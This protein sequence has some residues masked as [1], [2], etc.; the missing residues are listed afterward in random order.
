[1]TSISSLPISIANVQIDPSINVAI[2]NIGTY[3][4]NEKAVSQKLSDDFVCVAVNNEQPP[5]T[6]R[7][8]AILES[9]KKAKE[10]MAYIPRICQSIT[11]N[12][13]TPQKTFAKIKQG[14]IWE[15]EE[16]TFLI[17]SQVKED[18]QSN[19]EGKLSH[20]NLK[21]KNLDLP[22]L[23]RLEDSA[24][25]AD[26]CGIQVKPTALE[27]LT[28]SAKKAQDL[29]L[30]IVLAS[31]EKQTEAIRAVVA[32]DLSGRIVTVFEGNETE[33]Q[34]NNADSFI[35]VLEKYASDT[36]A[37]REFNYEFELPKTSGEETIIT[38]KYKVT[39]LI[40]KDGQILE[41]TI[42]GLAKW[43]FDAQR[44]VLTAATVFNNLMI[45]PEKTQNFQKEEKPAPLSTRYCTLM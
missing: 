40:Q 17:L 8:A 44:Q 15:M 24:Q 1:M 5:V 38:V 21:E 22:R 41:R 33:V 14:I 45:T 11:P 29:I 42:D 30:D 36:R 7:R 43:T 37:I 25:G 32:P 27:S 12:V 6:M 2:N 9:C 34:M 18:W 19:A 26:L 23:L 13:N 28:Q 31:L 16:K 35:G 39:T 10:Y 4:G 20:L 3:L